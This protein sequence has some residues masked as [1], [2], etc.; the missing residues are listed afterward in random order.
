MEWRYELKIGCDTR[1]GQ[2]MRTN[3]RIDHVA[4]FVT[5]AKSFVPLGWLVVNTCDR[6][7][8][9]KEGLCA[10]TTDTI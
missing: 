3:K 5:P 7:W 9:L 1:Q 10:R 8:Y 2:D 4:C 6:P